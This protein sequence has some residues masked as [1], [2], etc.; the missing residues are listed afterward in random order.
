MNNKIVSLITVS[1]FLTLFGCG[2]ASES[3]AERQGTIAADDSASDDNS[4]EGYYSED[5]NSYDFLCRSEF[6]L[7]TLP[8]GSKHLIEVPVACDPNPFRREDPEERSSFSAHEYKSKAQNKQ[9]F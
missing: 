3:T 8:D 7:I 1:L 5:G 9:S 4:Y 6:H 2:G